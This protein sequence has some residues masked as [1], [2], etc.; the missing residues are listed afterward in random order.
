MQLPIVLNGDENAA[1]GWTT[2]IFETAQNKP[3]IFS[4]TL[5]SYNALNK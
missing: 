3:S 1:E 4:V 5:D 2:K